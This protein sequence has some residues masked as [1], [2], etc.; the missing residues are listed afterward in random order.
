[1]KNAR[2]YLTHIKAL[3]TLNPQVV[4]WKVMR[5]EAQGDM[6]LFRYRL[7]LRDGGLL[8]MLE[9]FQ[10]AGGRLQVLKRSNVPTFARSNVKENHGIVI[11]DDPMEGL[12]NENHRPKSPR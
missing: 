3:I 10:V 11:L 9:C 8:E 12:Q 6:G 5:E 7:T 1:V 2:D 4:H